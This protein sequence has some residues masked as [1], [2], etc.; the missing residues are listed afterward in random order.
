MGKAA[1]RGARRGATGLGCA[2]ALVALAALGG[3]PPAAEAQTAELIGP[4]DGR[5]PFNCRLQDVGTGTDFP[6]PDADPFC[7]R[8]DKTNQN[9]TD[10]GIVDFLLQEPLRVAKGVSKCF[11]FQRDEWQGSI[12]QGSEPELWHWNGNYFVDRAKGVG[13]VSLRDLRALGSPV[14]LAPL[15]PERFHPF[16]HP[17]GGVGAAVLLE[18]NPDPICGALV[19]TPEEREAVYRDLPAFRDCIAP[20]GELS[21]RRVGK[22]RLGMRRAKVQRRLGAP[23]RSRGRGDRWCVIGAATLRVAYRR[24]P[25]GRRGAALIRT[26]SRGHRARGVGRGTPSRRA[27]RRLGLRPRFRIGRT[28]VLEAP[29]RRARRIYAGA[30]DGRVRWLAIADPRRLPTLRTTRRALRRTP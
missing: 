1:K 15:V 21:G 9:V 14:D 17:S 19:D 29:R 18:T 5:N 28:R 10:L 7:V 23:R 3:S 30:R 16:L 12:V 13:G 20:G 22:V 4:W 26:T 8:F 2:A 25:G 11:Y 27:T 6:E 24:G